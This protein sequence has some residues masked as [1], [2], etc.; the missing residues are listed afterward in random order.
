LPASSPSSTFILH[1]ENI[2][3]PITPLAGAGQLAVDSAE[4]RWPLVARW[5]QSKEDGVIHWYLAG[6]HADGK[7]WGYA[8]LRLES[9][10]VNC[11]FSG[12]LN[13]DALRQIPAIVEVLAVPSPLE[14]LRW[15]AEFVGIG[16]HSSF[17]RIF[18]LPLEA[19][20]DL[21]P[22]LVAAYRRFVELLQPAATLSIED[23]IA[24]AEYDD[25][26]SEE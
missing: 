14:P 4:Q 7:Y 26:E 6:L 9:R 16:T 11:G 12:T 8:H 22:K 2:G 17:Q 21:D 10:R 15:S 25:D 24:N 1:V 5:K 19:D 13:S 3:Y 18:E 23:A 20:R